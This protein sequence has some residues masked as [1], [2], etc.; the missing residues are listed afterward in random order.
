M[1]SAYWDVRTCC[2][3]GGPDPGSPPPIWIAVPA[4]ERARERGVHVPEQPTVTE[5]AP[6][7]EAAQ[8]GL[9]TA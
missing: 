2:W 4:A 3:Q 5:P 9:T 6:T 1:S 7:A 8:V